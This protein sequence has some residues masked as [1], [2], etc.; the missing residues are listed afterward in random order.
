MPKIES[1]ER[2]YCTNCAGSGEGM[3]DGTR[4]YACRG[5]GLERDWSAEEDYLAEQADAWNDERKCRENL[6]SDV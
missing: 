4:C 3:Y 6:R 1:E 2:G 5:T